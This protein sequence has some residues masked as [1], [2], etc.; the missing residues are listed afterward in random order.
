MRVL[1]FIVLLA[2]GLDSAIARHKSGSSSSSYKGVKSSSELRNYG[3]LNGYQ[4]GKYDYLLLAEIWTAVYCKQS[5]CGSA[6]CAAIVDGSDYAANH[7][8]LHGLWPQ[9][10]QVVPQHTL[11][12]NERDGCVYPQF[13]TKEISEFDASN[14]PQGA[15]DYAPAWA[16]GLG[17]HEW[18]KHGSCAY[19]FD[20]PLDSVQAQKVYFNTTLETFTRDKEF[21][22]SDLIGKRIAVEDLY[23]RLDFGSGLG[24]T[25]NCELEALFTCWSKDSQNAPAQRIDCPQVGIIDSEYSNGCQKC[26]EI[27][28]PEFPCSN[29]RASMLL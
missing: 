11:G 19:T 5:G 4:F 28:V 2:A 22:V 23:S 16:V 24:C 7:F 18:Q 26:T 12:C 25:N 3:G 27:L 13:C 14:L 20:L 10:S 15:K 1:L 6:E 21:V 9:F 29:S 8:A 17:E